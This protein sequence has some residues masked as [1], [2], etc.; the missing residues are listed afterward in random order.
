V[1]ALF[2]WFGIEDTSLAF[3]AA[4]GV[5]GAALIG[6]RAARDAW[7]ALGEDRADSPGDLRPDPAHQRLASLGLYGLAAGALAPALSAALMVVKISLHSHAT[8]DFSLEEV[9]GLLWRA[10]VWAGAGLLAGLGLGLW[11]LARRRGPG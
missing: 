2:I 11:R 1:L 8:P 10:P 4:L 7:Q 5:G 3:V 9:M 6:G